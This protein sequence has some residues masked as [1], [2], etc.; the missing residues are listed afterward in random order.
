M[1]YYFNMKELSVLVYQFE[2]HIIIVLCFRVKGNA[3]K[4]NGI[5]VYFVFVCVF[6]YTLRYGDKMFPQRRHYNPQSLSLW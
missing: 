4:L 2:S 1:M 5:G 6:R 3:C